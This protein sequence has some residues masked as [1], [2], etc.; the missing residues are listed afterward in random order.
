MRFRK[1]IKIAPGVKL[2]VSKSGISGTFGVKGASVNVGKNGVFA[3]TG[4][5]GT[6]IYDRQK[7]GGSAPGADDNIEETGEPG[8]AIIA[9]IKA[10]KSAPAHVAADSPPIDTAA[11]SSQIFTL[12][13]NYSPFHIPPV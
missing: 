6:G 1:S 5:P 7:I 10:R 12:I 8:D 2:N 9:A 3:N 13:F 11:E 4:I